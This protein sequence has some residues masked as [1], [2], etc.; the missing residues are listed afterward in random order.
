MTHRLGLAEIRGAAPANSN[1]PEVTHASSAGLF[2]AGRELRHEFVQQRLPRPLDPL[3]DEGGV[4]GVNVVAQGGG[5]DLDAA[6]D[7][8]VVWAHVEAGDARQG[9][10]QVMLPVGCHRDPVQGEGRRRRPWRA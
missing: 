7:G 1:R 8:G 10:D 6:C 2:K 3:A 5:E 9:Q 4:L